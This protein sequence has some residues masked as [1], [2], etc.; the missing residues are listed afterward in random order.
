VNSIRSL[1]ETNRWRIAEA[2]R[3]HR[4]GSRADLERRTGVSGRGR[5]AM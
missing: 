5:R 2:L 1:R 3:I 4:S